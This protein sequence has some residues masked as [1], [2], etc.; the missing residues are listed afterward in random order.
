MP[1][2]SELRDVS[3]A[4][5]R[6]RIVS[7]D[8]EIALRGAR[9][10]DVVYLDP[11]YPPLNGTA[12]FTH[13]TRA[14]FTVDEQRRVAIQFR[15]LDALGC[16]VLLSNTDR[17]EIRALYRGYYLKSFPTSR[18]VAAHGHRYQVNDLLVANFPLR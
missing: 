5:A 3:A 11:P 17:A 2:L 18:F 15:K 6:V 4:L 12:F 9:K 1:S 10:G 7:G 13:Y 14:R 16:R 8:F